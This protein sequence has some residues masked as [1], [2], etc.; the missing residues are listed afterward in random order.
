MSKGFADITV[1]L[2]GAGADSAAAANESEA[3]EDVRV[4]LYLYGQTI[5]L[6]VIMLPHKRLAYDLH[7]MPAFQRY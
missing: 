2:R 5:L 4:W 3:S 6:T 1:L 7:G